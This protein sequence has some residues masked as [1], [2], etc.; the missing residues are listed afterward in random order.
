MQ[1]SHISDIPILVIFFNRP[2]C[3]EQLLIGLV[4]AGAKNIYFAAD[5]P[6][7]GSRVD[8]SKIEACMVL[9]KSFASN[10]NSVHF[11]N[12]EENF[13]C[14]IFVPKAISWFF[15]IEE[16]GIILEDD[17][18][19]DSGFLRFADFALE[20]YRNV[21]E[22]MSISAANFQ[23]HRVGNGD[24]FYSRYPYIWGWATW[25]RSWRY[26]QDDANVLEQSISA[27]D[28]L[29]K[30]FKNKK[31]A[32]HWHKMLSSLAAKKI[33]FWDA[34]WYFSMWLREGFSLTPNMNLVRNIGFG[35]DA[36]HTKDERENPK[37]KIGTFPSIIISPSD[38][39]PNHN[40]DHELFM[41]RFSPNLAGYLRVAKSKLL[42]FLKPN[43]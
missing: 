27:N 29:N 23:N 16:R 28:T 26:Y 35:G 36:T 19:I 10:F 34:K 13:G 22:V 4:N 31:Q 7:I 1:Q 12:A 41:R 11:F 24:Y 20:K 6:R 39:W 21:S 2:D 25:A 30:I 43:N 42:Q 40:A 33:N 18:I 3:L 15:S 32:K 9:A 8:A 17:C 37:M 14:D 5:G 38:P